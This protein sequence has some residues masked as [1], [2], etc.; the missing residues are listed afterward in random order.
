MS[1]DVKAKQGV[2]YR[3]MTLAALV[4]LV[5]AYL[6]PIWWVS[7]TAPQYPQEAFPDGIRIHFHFDGVF[8]GCK[9]IEKKEIDE[10]DDALDCKHEMDAINHYV[11]MYPIAAGAPVE[12]ALSPFLVSILG[13][14]MVAFMMP[15][16]KQAVAVMAVGGAAIVVW[17][18]AA[19]FMPGGV[20]LFSPNFVDDMAATMSLTDK[21]YGGWTGM[22]AIQNSY[23]EGLGRYFRETKVIENAVAAMTTAT[24]V[25]YGLMVAAIVVLIVG[26]ALVPAA[27]WLLG[28]VPAIL[29][30]AFVADYASW[31]YWFGHNL[32][33]MG[34]F[35]VKPFMPTVFGQGKV[36]QFS[37]FSYPTYGYGLLLALAALMVVAALL[38][39]KQL[40]NQQPVVAA[41]RPAKAAA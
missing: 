38:R 17:A 40:K 19:L 27:P 13:V 23:E 37:T 39:R 12:R 6:S 20:K 35:T 18:S 29:P 24:Y 21:E 31:L 15:K 11:G 41:S 10:G 7:L 34:A 36:A 14:V 22:Q 4:L 3:A 30:I 5:A 2:A 32:N 26:V 9:L 28:L 8:N 33:D 1:A 16:R 25:V